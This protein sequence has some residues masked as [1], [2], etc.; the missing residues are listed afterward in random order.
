[1]NGNE[2]SCISD[3]YEIEN[4]AGIEDTRFYNDPIFYGVE[5][6]NAKS[7]QVST[8]SGMYGAPDGTLLSEFNG[9]SGRQLL[10]VM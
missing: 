10:D 5:V 2:V 8:I 4:L 6:D 1:M 9:I 3:D 7:V